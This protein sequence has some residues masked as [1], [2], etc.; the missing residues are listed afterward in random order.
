MKSIPPPMTGTSSPGAWT[1][2]RAFSPRAGIPLRYCETGT[3]FESEPV[4]YRYLKYQ[5]I[6]IEEQ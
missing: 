2:L 3:L 5:Q 4:R 1:G 6:R